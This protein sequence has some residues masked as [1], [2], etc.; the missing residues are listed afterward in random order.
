MDFKNYRCILTLMYV[1]IAICSNGYSQTSKQTTIPAGSY[2]IDMGIVPQTVNN[3][4]KPYGLVYALL[5]AHCPVDWVINTLK[6]KDGPDFFYNGY[7]YRGGPFII[8]AKY[9]SVQINAI[10]SKWA[11]ADN[12]GIVG[13]TTTSPV[14][15][16]VYLTFWN[17][18][19]WTLDAENGILAVNFFN[20]AGIPEAAYGGPSSNWKTPAQLGDCDDVYVMPHASPEWTSHSHLLDWVNGTVSGAGSNTKGALWVG[21]IGGSN[22]MDM[23]DNVTPDYN[24]QTN[25]LADKSGSAFGSGPYYENSLILPE[26]H[27]NGTPPYSYDYSGEPEM[28]FMGTM[29]GAQ[30]GGYEQIYIPTGGTEGWF[31]NTHMGVYD[32]K[33]PQRYNLSDKKAYRA[34]SLVYGPGMGNPMNGDVM[35]EGG[36]NIAGTLP[37][38]IAAQRAFFNFSFDEACKKAYIPSLDNLPDTIY[39]NKTYTLTYS[40]ANNSIPLPNQTYTAVWS[41]N[42]GGQW[43]KGTTGN[44]PTFSPA[45]VSTP[46]RCIITVEITDNCGRMTFDTH[47]VLVLPCK[48]PVSY[49]I[50]NPTCTADSTGSI[51]LNVS[52]DN[53]PYNWVLNP[54]NRATGAS[55]GTGTMISNLTQG[56]YVYNLTNSIGCVSGTSDII[57]IQAKSAMPSAPVVGV[58]TQPTCTIPT[59]SVV[60][61]GLPDTGTWTLTVMPGGATITGTGKSTTLSFLQSGTYTY[62]VAN[63][64]GCS[65]SASQSIFIDKLPVSPATPTVVVFKQPTCSLSTGTLE[66]NGLPA[67]GKWSLSISPGGVTTTGTG[68]STTVAGFQPGTYTWVVTNDNGCPS[69]PADNITINNQ[70]VTPAIPQIMEMVV[71]NC[72]VNTASFKGISSGSSGTTYT[73]EGTAYTNTT[74]LFTLIPYGTY[75][76]IAKSIDGCLSLSTVVEVIPKS[77]CNPIAVDDVSNGKADTPVTGNVADNDLAVSEVVNTWKLLGAN[78]GAMHGTVVMNI[79]GKFTYTPDLDFLG[80]DSFTYEMCTEGNPPQCST[81][82]VS[83]NVE[84]DTNCPVFVPNSFSPNGDGVHDTFKV[85][86]IYNY[87]NAV[88]EIYNRAG[89]LIYVNNHYGN[90]DFWGSE[91]RAWWS[92]RSSSSLTL[93]NEILPVGTYYY[94][95]TLER[96]K[97][98]NG[99]IFL[100]R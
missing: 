72:M 94:V 63:E 9:R 96:S 22:L 12:S 39:S 35:L 83:V 40:A 25:F 78:G 31:L 19:R 13:I 18:P 28:Q 61:S 46:T 57:V 95:L 26:N 75:N 54:L 73:L 56:S 66:F 51:A 58:V 6:S 5:K 60:L 17:E 49:M 8:E 79:Y 88:M 21:C 30:Q 27:Q 48:I 14:I 80:S 52:D 92:G 97:I 15:V 47:S 99:I 62:T 20:Y 71:P 84:K 23:F 90:L 67:S 34:A 32:P 85:K 74:G 16:P 64:A 44:S 91:D 50:T 100:N 82:K 37:A 70:P 55:T 3:G 29:D 87:E 7:A 38:N 86:C 2:I 33:H 68:V 69:L 1:M 41:V 4:L 43:K 76:L 98:L 59:G 36:H 24:K 93:G 65:S 45:P 42:I 77:D 53:P 81:A 89:N 11:P 10:I